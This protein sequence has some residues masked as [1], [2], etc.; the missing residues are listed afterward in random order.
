MHN[1]TWV[2][3]RDRDDSPKSLPVYRPPL[4]GIVTEENDFFVEQVFLDFSHFSFHAALK[5]HT[6]RS[7][8]LAICMQ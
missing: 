1:V 6:Y 5:I 7:G 8:C 4:F 3:N 2:F